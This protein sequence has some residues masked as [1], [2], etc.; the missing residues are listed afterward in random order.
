VGQQKTIF[1][2]RESLRVFSR[3]LYAPLLSLAFFWLA[4]AT[5]LVSG[6]SFLSDQSFGI[7]AVA[8]LLGM[9]PNM[10]YRLLTGILEKILQGGALP[11]AREK[12][13]VPG[14]VRVPAGRA[15]SEGPDFSKLR[16]RIADM[17]TAPLQP[18]TIP[19]ARSIERET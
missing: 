19:P 5:N 3:L 14:K 8:F 18:A 1:Q 17:F 4:T 10:I 6:P 12:P 13:L 15:G 7:L 11:P 9:Y 16:E 2:P